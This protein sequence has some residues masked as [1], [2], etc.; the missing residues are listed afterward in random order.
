MFAV[1]MYDTRTNVKMNQVFQLHDYLISSCRKYDVVVCKWI[2]KVVKMGNVRRF[3][4]PFEQIRRNLYD[5]NLC[6][7]ICQYFHVV[8]YWS[9]NIL[10]YNFGWENTEE[11]NTYP[12]IKWDFQTSTCKF[13]PFPFKVKSVMNAR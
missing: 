10:C 9:Q 2:G 5:R 12:C 3:H 6:D 4:E 13:S 1:N 7:Q 11:R 8:C